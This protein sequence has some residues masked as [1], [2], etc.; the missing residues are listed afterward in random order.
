[1]YKLPN[2]FRK[3]RRRWQKI[4][5]ARRRRRR[6]GLPGAPPPPVH[7]WLNAAADPKK[8]GAHLYTVCVHSR[9]VRKE[10]TRF[11]P[12]FFWQTCRGDPRAHYARLI[13]SI[14]AL[15]RDYLA[16]NLISFPFDY[17]YITAERG[18]GR[19]I[20]DFF[21]VHG[22]RAFPIYS[23]SLRLPHVQEYCIYTSLVI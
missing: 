1:M 16:L 13:S 12:W 2:F 3:R 21:R 5:A 17:T 23:S 6:S 9:S 8:I 15:H 7:F 20:Y 4:A 19:K 14:F 10:A 22:D 11:C 18:T